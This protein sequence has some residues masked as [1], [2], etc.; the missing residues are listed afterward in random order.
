MKR[1]FSAVLLVAMLLTISATALAY[2]D[3]ICCQHET[4]EHHDFEENVLC[5]TEAKTMKALTAVGCER[6]KSTDDQRIY[7]YHTV[8]RGV[9]DMTNYFVPT[10]RYD[11]NDTYGSK[12]VTPG[13]K[14]PIR[15]DKTVTRRYYNIKARGNTDHALSGYST[16]TIYGYY[17]VH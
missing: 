9:S 5:S 8:Y 1:F 6:Y 7:V 14:I 15:S 16:I 2:D 3:N 10:D 4:N 17:S 13:L 11:L 12:W